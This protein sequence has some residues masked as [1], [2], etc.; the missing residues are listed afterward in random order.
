MPRSGFAYGL[1]RP[2]STFKACAPSAAADSPHVILT[3]PLKPP[4]EIRPNRP[5]PPTPRLLAVY[6]P[7][8][9]PGNPA[10]QHHGL[11]RAGG[12]LY[13]GRPAP[14]PA[15]PHHFLV[16]Q[17]GRRGVP[18]PGARTV[19]PHPGTAGG[20]APGISQPQSDG[21]LRGL[22][23]RRLFRYGP[24]RQHPHPLRRQRG[25]LRGALR[26]GRDRHG[27]GVPRHRV[28][29]HQV[30]GSRHPQLHARP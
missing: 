5:R 10:H 20:P 2:G 18:V 13:A 17:R 7:D 19:R 24:D 30:P 12:G 11:L 9:A 27:L 23:R 21:R 3:R 22:D 28:G 4:H 29:R 8:Y 6:E 15:H 1:Q 25:R 16:L 26:P 14:G